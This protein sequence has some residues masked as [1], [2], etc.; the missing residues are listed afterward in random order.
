MLHIVI[1]AVDAVP[2]VVAIVV[3]A[4][5]VA[6]VAVVSVAAI[7]AVAT[8]VAVV[9]VA[10]VVAVVALLALLLH[11]VLFPSS[12]TELLISA[13]TIF[14]ITHCPPSLH[15]HRANRALSGWEFAYC[16]PARRAR[17]YCVSNNMQQWRTTIY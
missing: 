17:P 5:A 1:V 8:V 13:P 16:C 11:H 15:R 9:A 12:S 4:T 7:V 10:T 3:V 2:T 6:V 14:S